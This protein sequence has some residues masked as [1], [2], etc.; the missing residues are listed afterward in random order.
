MENYAIAAFR[1]RQAVFRFENRLRQLSI[2]CRIVSTPRAVSLGCGLSLRFERND[3]P[4]ALSALDDASRLNL[5]GFFLVTSG[6]GGLQVR[7]IGPT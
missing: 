7:P 4:R 6:P 3:L 1:S 5:I 2:P